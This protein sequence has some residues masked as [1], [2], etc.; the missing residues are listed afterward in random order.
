MVGQTAA[1]L[2]LPAELRDNIVA[3]L[4][5]KDVLSLCLVRTPAPALLFV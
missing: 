4:G 5:I 3:C 2:D 1:I